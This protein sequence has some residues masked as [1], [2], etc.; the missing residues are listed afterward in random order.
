VS[1]DFRHAFPRLLPANT[2]IRLTPHLLLLM[3]VPPPLP[4]PL[5]AR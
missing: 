3:L 2:E 5:A 1:R 4:L